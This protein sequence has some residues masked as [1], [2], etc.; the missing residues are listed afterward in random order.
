MLLLML[1]ALFIVLRACTAD[2]TGPVQTPAAV[3][4]EPSAAE[5][6][7]P[8]PS[9]TPEPTPSPSPTP[10]PTPSPEPT[11]PPAIDTGGSFRSDTGTVLNL[12]ADWTAVSAGDG[13]VT[14]T[15]TLSVESY[16]L[17]CSEIY[18]GAT[19]TIGSET[20]SFDTPAIAYDG[21]AGLASTG[22]GSVSVT[23]T[24][25]EAAAGTIPVTASWKFGGTY[26]GTDLPV[27]TAQGTAGLG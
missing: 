20:R 9:P 26:S 11:P 13:N 1:V 17:Q 2:G 12:V 19:V 23:L 16:S 7:R 3:S 27:I 15:V 22:I 5:T 10:E 8:T 25:D 14:V 6:D 18:K 21:S 4:A 24:A